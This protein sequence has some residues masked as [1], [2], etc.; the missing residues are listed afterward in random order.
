MFP[1]LLIEFWKQNTTLSVA[2]KNPSPSIMDMDQSFF[3]DKLKFSPYF[4]SFIFI[5]IIGENNADNTTNNH[6]FPVKILY[7]C[8]KPANPSPA[9]MY[10]DK[11]N[12]FVSINHIMPNII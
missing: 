3:H 5:T 4:F 1:Y 10:D 8:N 12:K 6:R 7:D 9:L 2:D 11:S